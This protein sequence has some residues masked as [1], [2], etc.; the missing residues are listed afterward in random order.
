M[1]RESEILPLG[2]A[3]WREP[4]RA[5]ED[6]CAPALLKTARMVLSTQRASRYSEQCVT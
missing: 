6:H 3:I 1:N 4:C 5:E 2:D